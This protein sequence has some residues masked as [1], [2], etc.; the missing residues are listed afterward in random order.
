MISDYYYSIAIAYYE[1]SNDQKYH[2]SDDKC[3]RH[4]LIREYAEWLYY[5]TECNNLWN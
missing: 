2:Q 1:N 5:I 4:Y 3:Y